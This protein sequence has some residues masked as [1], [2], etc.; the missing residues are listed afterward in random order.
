M[1]ASNVVVLRHYLQQ[2]SSLSGSTRNDTE[3]QMPPTPT[4]ADK[5]NKIKQNI[6]RTDSD[7]VDVM[8]HGKGN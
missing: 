5:S 8:T 2:A 7:L 3:N 1:L 6:Y 4:E